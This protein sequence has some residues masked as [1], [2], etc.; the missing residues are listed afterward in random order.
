MVALTIESMIASP[1]TL[2][3]A[4]LVTLLIA[5]DRVTGCSIDAAYP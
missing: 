2:L 1:L 3:F 5:I 4:L